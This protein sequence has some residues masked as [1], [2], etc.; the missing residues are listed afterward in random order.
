MCGIFCR[1]FLA[2]GL[3]ASSQISDIRHCAQDSVAP[4]HLAHLPLLLHLLQTHF[5]APAAEPERAQVLHI[6][7]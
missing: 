6:K 2:G 1:T 5:K 4:V 3:H 7:E